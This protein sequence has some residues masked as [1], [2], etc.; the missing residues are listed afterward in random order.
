MNEPAFLIVDVYG[1]LNGSQQISTKPRQDDFHAVWQ[2]DQ[3]PVI[4][5]HTQPSQSPGETQAV[6]VQP[7]I[8]ERLFSL[9]LERLRIRALRSLARQHTADRPAI[10]QVPRQDVIQL[11][12]GP[13]LPLTL[14]DQ[15]ILYSR[16]YGKRRCSCSPLALDVGA[17]SNPGVLPLSLPW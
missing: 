14:R 6:F 5:L 2:H 3:H 10:L 17:A 1:N 11:H 9:P 15:L 4:G 8:R 12:D 7:C 16:L 13:P